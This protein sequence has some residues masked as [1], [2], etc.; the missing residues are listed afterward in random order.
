MW[1]VVLLVALLIAA[2]VAY[3]VWGRGAAPRT[4]SHLIDSISHDPSRL[5]VCRD[6]IDLYL[7]AS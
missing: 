7:A 1:I 4:T 2:A 5:D 6:R 3:V